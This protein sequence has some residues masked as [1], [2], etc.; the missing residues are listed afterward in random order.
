[1]FE[2]LL[3][4]VDPWILDPLLPAQSS[5]G[6]ALQAPSTS[7]QPTSKQTILPWVLCG[8]SGRFFSVFIDSQRC[9]TRNA[10]FFQRN[11][12][13]IFWVHGTLIRS[14]W[15]GRSR[16]YSEPKTPKHTPQATRREPRRGT[17]FWLAFCELSGLPDHTRTCHPFTPVQAAHAFSFSAP[18]S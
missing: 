4:F 2:R 12:H 18:S 16:F 17:V 1:M 15:R 6:S 7:H 9:K 10:F 14:P 3:R 8:A 11:M 5:R 13:L